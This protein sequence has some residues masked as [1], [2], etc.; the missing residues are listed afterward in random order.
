MLLQALQVGIRNLHKRTTT[1]N[2]N[3]NNLA[4]ASPNNRQK[5]HACFIHNSKMYIHGKQG[6]S[7][8]RALYVQSLGLSALLHCNTMQAEQ[9]HTV[10]L[11]HVH[12]LLPTPF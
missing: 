9:M 3:K 6:S 10:T 5:S 8:R 7:E 11:Y 4:L 2:N 1:T 12:P